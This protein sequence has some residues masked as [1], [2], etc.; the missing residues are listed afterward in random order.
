MLVDEDLPGKPACQ[1]HVAADAAVMADVPIVIEGALPRDDCREPFGLA[2]RDLP[3][4]DR[5]IRNAEQA[6]LAV[7]PRLA[8][9]PGDDSCE[10]LDLARR[11]TVEIA[12]RSIAAARVCVND[13]VAVRDPGLR[14]GRFPADEAA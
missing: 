13:D 6:D 12:G 10:I 8:R 7:A 1:E 3:L 5:V 2:R 14:I 4:R 11:E 9:R